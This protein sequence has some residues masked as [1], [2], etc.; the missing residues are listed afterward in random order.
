MASTNTNTM[1]CAACGKEG[2]NLNTCNKCNM[3][4]YC[5]AACKKKH[6][7]KHKK[8]CER[9]VAELHD[10]AL[11]KEPP[12]REECPICFLPLPLDPSEVNFKSCCGKI[13]C[14]GCIYAMR[15]EARGRGKRS[16]CA[17]CRVP[18]HSSD[19]EN[20]KR[21]MKLM[22]SENA[23][24]FNQLAG[25]YEHRIMGMPQDFEKANELYLR[26]GE[27]GCAEAYCNL[28]NSHFYGRGVEVDKKKAKHLYELAAM[29][30]NVTARYNVGNVEERAGN[31]T[32]ACKHYIIAAKAG[33]KKSLDE[34]KEWFMMRMV[35]KDEYADTLRAFHKQQNEMKSHMRDKARAARNG[36]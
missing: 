16:L 17:F 4:K 9:R 28:G 27:L 24:S 12:P 31:L 6:R 25:Y 36:R 15:E 35:T 14:N 8:A 19:E 10:E 7:S 29:N 3:I 20:I 18:T 26:A 11:F 30:G 22:D 5:N 33:Y 21:T 2:G 32:R 1:N 34:V 13:I 23:T